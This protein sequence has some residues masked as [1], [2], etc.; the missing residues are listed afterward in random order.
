MED[1]PADVSSAANIET[2][3]GL[4][5]Q[6]LVAHSRYRLAKQRGD[7][8]AAKQAKKVLAEYQ[9]QVFGS[10]SYSTNDQLRKDEWKEIDDTLTAVARDNTLGLDTLRDRGIEVPLDLGTLRFSWESI[11]DFGEAD[12]D[13]AATQGGG[14]DTFNYENDGI[15]LPIVHKSFKINLRKLRS[16]R[17]RGQPIDTAGVEAATAAVTRKLEDIL[18][19]GNSITVDGD[20]IAGFTD[21]SARQTVAGHDWSS[22]TSDEIISD[23]MATISALE[24]AKAL[25]G[26]SGYDFLIA[27]QQYQEIRAKNAGTDNKQGVLQ[28]LRRRLEEEEGLPSQVRFFPVD[29]LSSGN[30]VMV[31]PTER[32]VQLPMPADIQ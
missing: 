4:G 5:Y 6:K 12:V 17:N 7:E 9:K 22:A 32:Y 23:V 24:D 13:M 20:S 15:P 14:E 31:K 3:G 28:L 21:F 10:N 18:Y 26:Q 30:A 29:R 1:G 27:R 11:S 19:G 8:E 2:G 25:P 16:S